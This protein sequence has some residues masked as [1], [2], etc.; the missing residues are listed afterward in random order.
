MPPRRGIILLARGNAL[1]SVAANLE[2]PRRGNIPLAQGN[3]LGPWDTGFMN[4]NQYFPLV[5]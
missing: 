5:G 3:T 2:S 1:G 4:P